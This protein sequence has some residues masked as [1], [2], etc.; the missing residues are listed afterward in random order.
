MAPTP[1]VVAWSGGKDSAL[2]VE[3]LRAEGRHEIVALV[4]TV[5]AAFD[6]VSIHGVRRRIL[7]AQAESLGL[8]LVEAYLPFPA[9]NAIYDS[10]FA[11]A[12]EA[13]RAARPGVRTIAFGDLFLEDVRAYRERTLPPLGWQPIFPLWEEPTGRLARRFIA[14]G[15]RAVLCCVDTEQLEPAFAGREFDE[16]L[17]DDLPPTVDPCGE[18]GEFHTC[19]YEGP[20]FEE[21]LELKRGERVLREERFEYCD[22]E[23]TDHP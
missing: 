12:L 9:S 7:H 23:L 1:I 20:I 5:T 4:T 2:L 10:V 18:R 11:G 8:P 19:V 16:A 6:R 13:V 17:L 22:L 3:R 15:F 14:D 21:A